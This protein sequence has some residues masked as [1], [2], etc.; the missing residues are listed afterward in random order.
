MI[1][2]RTILKLGGAAFLTSRGVT[3]AQ[4]APLVISR[5]GLIFT[6]V[7]INGRNAKALVDTGSVRGLQLSQPLASTL[8]LKLSQTGHTTQRYDG[9]RALLAATL[10]TFELDGKVSTDEPASVSP[11]DIEDIARQTGE[12]FDAIL[13]WPILSRLPLVIDYK[14]ATIAFGKARTGGVALPLKAGLRVPVTSGTIAGAAVDFL[15]DTGAPWC[16]IDPSL[17]HGAAVGERLEMPFKIGGRDFKAVF[18]VKDLGAMT[19]GNGARAVLGHRFLH[20]FHFAWSP[21]DKL[22]RLI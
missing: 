6:T 1:D 13:G 2:R 8:G 3:P 10:K 9:A 18:R 12:P 16:N 14:A 22:V 19:R 20:G 4:A 17:A 15:I 5:S 21:D 11:G 7:R